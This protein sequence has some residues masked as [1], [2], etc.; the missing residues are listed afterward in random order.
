MNE[1]QHGF[2]YW[3]FVFIGVIYLAKFI[4]TSDF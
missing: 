3:M 1:K 2:V 4:L